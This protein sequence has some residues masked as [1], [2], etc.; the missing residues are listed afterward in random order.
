MRKLW[1]LVMAAVMLAGCAT[2]TTM[3]TVADELVLAESAMKEITMELPGEPVLPVMQTDTGEIYIC[4]D[5]EVSVETLPG[6]D[7]QR[8]VQMLTGFGMEDVTVME[9]TVGERTRYDLAWSAMG[10]TGPEVGR[11]AVLCDGQ[12][13]YCLTVMTAEENAVSCREMFNGLFESFT[14]E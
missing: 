1:V 8:T 4:E 6:G 7:I 2:E 9:T 14:L 10:E 12:Y 5:F 3:E 11:A 13:H